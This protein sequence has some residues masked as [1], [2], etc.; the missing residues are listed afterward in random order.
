MADFGYDISDHTGVDPL[1]GTLADFDRLLAEAHRRG[2]RVIVDYVPNHTSDRHP[3]FVEARASRRSPR[4]DFYLWRDPGPGGG[5]PTNW[6]GTFGGSAWTLDPGTGQYYYHAFL[7]EQPDL[8]WR[9]PRVRAA[10]LDVLRFWLARGVDGFRVDAL[11][12]LY[13]DDRWRDEPPD[14]DWRPGQDP[15]RALRPI[16]TTDLPEVL[17]AVRALRETVE[18]WPGRVLIGELYLPLDRLA[19]YYLADGEGSARGLHLPFN[20]HLIR[21]PWTAEAIADLVRR[22]EAVLPPG[23]WPNWVLGNHDRPRIASRV[24]AAQARVA[25]MLLLTLR[26]TPTLYQ[27]DELGMEDVPVPPELVQDPWEKRVP[28]L[29]LGRDPVRAPLAWDGGPGGGFTTGTP[30]LPLAP[31]WRARNVATLRQDPRSILTLHRRLLALRRAVPALATGAIEVL[32]PD[33]DVL[34]YLRHGPGGPGLVALNLGSRPRTVQ[35]PPGLP[36]GAVALSTAL[37]RE[38]EPVGERLTLRAD[39]GVVVLPAPEGVAAARG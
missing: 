16:H 39:E 11:R 15:Y 23:A 4:R 22:Y 18:P 35:P 34:A 19:A 8:D 38:A 29:G 10:M 14:P 27:G 5:P 3:W 20:L 25:A 28:G 21:T 2:M 12:H 24:G 6:R 17:E 33:G 1:F 36:P 13:K 31:D 30:W 26:G 7:P 9:N 32:A 37:D